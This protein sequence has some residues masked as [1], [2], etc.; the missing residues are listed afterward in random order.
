MPKGKSLA[1]FKRE[2]LIFSI[3][4]V[5]LKPNLLP[6]IKEFYFWRSLFTC[7]LLKIYIIQRSRKTW[8]FFL[9]KLKKSYGSYT[10]LDF[11]LVAH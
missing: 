5:S 6:N 1:T 10:E 3:I 7:K 9:K 8:E 11:A 2:N 4:K